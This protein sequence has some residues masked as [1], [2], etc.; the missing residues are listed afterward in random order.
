MRSRSQK[1]FEGE[2]NVKAGEASV[3]ILGLLPHR[4]SLNEANLMNK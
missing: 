2:R 4:F 1:R 3:S